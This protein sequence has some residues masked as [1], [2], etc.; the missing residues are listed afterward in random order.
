MFRALYGSWPNDLAEIEAKTEGIDFAVF[1]GKAVVTPLHDDS[2]LV[3]IFDGV[4]TRQVK[5]VPVDLGVTDP[6]REAAKVPGFK[7]KV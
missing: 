2:E 3:Q 5:A 7:I 1:M 6:E 4:N